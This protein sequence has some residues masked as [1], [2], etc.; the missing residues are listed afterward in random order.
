MRPPPLCGIST[1]FQ[2]LSPC[3]GQVA[4]ALLTRPPLMRRASN[5]NLPPRAPVRLACVRHAA[6][7]HPE[8]GSNSH[9]CPLSCRLP[10]AGFTVFLGPVVF[11]TVFLSFEFPLNLP[12]ALRF[13]LPAFFLSG[14][15]FPAS[16][17]LGTSGIFRAALLFIC[18]GSITHKMFRLVFLRR[19]SFIISRLFP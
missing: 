7:V 19:N 16:R 11:S 13:F 3:T 6:S 17:F 10:S 15:F 4:H 8:P 9:V 2:V 1:C 12:S 5:R 14:F 18:Q